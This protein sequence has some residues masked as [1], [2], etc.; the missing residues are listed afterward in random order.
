MSTYIGGD[1]FNELNNYL[2]NYNFK[3]ISSNNFGNNFPD[4]TLTGFSEFDALFINKS[5]F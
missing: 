4:L 1:N 2:T 3:Y 5:A